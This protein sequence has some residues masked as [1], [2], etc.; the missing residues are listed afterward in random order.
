MTN[1]YTLDFTPDENRPNP[2]DPSLWIAAMQYQ[3]GLIVKPQKG[4]VD[5]LVIDGVEKVNEQ[6]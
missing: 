4:P 1:D 5:F 3:L 6:K 2:L